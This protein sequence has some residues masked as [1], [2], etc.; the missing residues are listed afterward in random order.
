MRFGA[1]LFQFRPTYTSAHPR[2]KNWAENG[3]ARV[4]LKTSSSLL[5]NPQPQNDHEAYNC[6]KRYITDIF[7]PFIDRMHAFLRS[8]I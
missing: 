8:F 6:Y 7:S 5:G 4:P 1:G 3:R 2:S